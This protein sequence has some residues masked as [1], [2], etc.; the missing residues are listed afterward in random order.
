VLLP[1]AQEAPG[2]SPAQAWIRD[3]VGFLSEML[4]VIL[5]VAVILV[6]L[7]LI[8]KAK[9]IGQVIG[10]VL[11]AA[12]VFFLLMNLDEVAQFFREELPIDQAEET[13]S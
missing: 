4:P 11:G 6:A 13:G 5:P 9:G 7:V 12:V 1:F 8:F 3:W 2:D 10:F